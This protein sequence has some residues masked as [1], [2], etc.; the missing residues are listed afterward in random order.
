M[1]SA[2][3]PTLNEED[4]VGPLVR[5]LAEEV[6]EVVV[7]DGQSAD[8]T[9]ERAREAGARVVV[10][11]PGRGPQLDRGADA[12]DGT[13]LWFV[14]ADCCVPVGL[15]AA[16]RL[17]AERHRWGGCTVRIDARDPRL[18]WTMF[19]MNRRA[20]WTGSMTGDMGIWCHRDLH[21][22]LGG[23]GTLSALEDLAFTDRAR[24]LAAW[25]VVRPALGTSS[26]R[27]TR[28]G[29]TRTMARMLVLRA[30]YRLG[31]SPAFL[32]GGYGPARA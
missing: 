1:L 19:V 5:R 10:G 26:R 24:A 8:R 22:A 6:D 7:S 13:V 3:I 14:H 30:A 11:P 4:R 25:G 9:V 2:V 20:R 31:V 27:W 17:A 15:G 32:A 21:E 23:F 16:V 29:V 28:N 12:A 18:C